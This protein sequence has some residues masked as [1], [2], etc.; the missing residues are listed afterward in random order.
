MHKKRLLRPTDYEL[1]KKQMEDSIKWVKDSLEDFFK[2]NS[3]LIE[4][5]LKEECI[6][7][8]FA[9]SLERHRPQAFSGYSVD[10]EYDK[11]GSDDK[12]MIED[13]TNKE[14]CIR[15]DII[16]HSRGNDVNV[17]AIECKKT[18]LVKKDKEKL[19][20]LSNQ[21]YSYRTVLGI[22]YGQGK[23]NYLLYIYDPDL[24]VFKLENVKKPVG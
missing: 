4:K 20:K 9:C 12:K 15:P 6:N 10:V 22:G 1:E 21:P 7:H 16:V 3:E 24:S 2:K 13:K 5:N 18:Y 19:K 17:L 8:Q 23:E 14:V 11:R